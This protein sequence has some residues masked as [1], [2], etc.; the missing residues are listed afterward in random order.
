MG[1]GAPA[2]DAGKG[3][4]RAESLVKQVQSLRKR[5]NSASDVVDTLEVS[6]RDAL[7]RRAQARTG[8]RPPGGRPR[9][10]G[11]RLRS[12]RAGR[13][14]Q[15]RAVNLSAVPGPTKGTVTIT[16]DGGRQVRLTPRLAQL[17]ALL[18]ANSILIDN[19]LVGWKPLDDLAAGLAKKTGGPVERHN[20]TNLI[21]RLRNELHY[22]GGY[23]RELVQ[24]DPRWGARFA[25]KRGD[26]R[27][28]A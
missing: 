14:A 24:T 1:M 15:P 9:R 18:V 4:D 6:L 3:K 2:P 20:V 21:Y 19:D 22:Q 23:P 25:L 11:P 26:D 12:A 17:L 8:A 16:V 10:T 28:P 7:R 27:L 5:L 13:S